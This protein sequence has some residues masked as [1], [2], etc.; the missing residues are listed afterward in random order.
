MFDAGDIRN[1]GL[2]ANGLEALRSA[3]LVGTP[4]SIRI[5]HAHA[6]HFN[7][8]PRI[9]AQS[10]MQDTSIEVAR[11]AFQNAVAQGMWQHA[12]LTVNSGR[13]IVQINVAGNGVDIAQDI[14]GNME[15][16]ELRSV[17]AAQRVAQAQN[18][19]Q[20]RAAQ[21]ASSPVTI[22]RDLRTG[23]TQLYTS[24]NTPKAF[25]EIVDIVGEGAFTSLLGGGRGGS[26]LVR[27]E[28]GHHGGTVSGS[29]AAEGYIRRLRLSMEA[30]GGRAELIT[31]T[32]SGFVD[33]STASVRVLQQIGVNATEVHG[34]TGNESGTPVTERQ[35]N[36]GRTLEI[37]QGQIVQVNQAVQRSQGILREA[38]QARQELISLLN[39]IRP[40]KAAF[41]Q[42]G[43]TELVRSM[44]NIERETESMRGPLSEKIAEF[45]TAFESEARNARGLNANMDLSNTNARLGQMRSLIRPERDVNRIRDSIITH[46][47]MTDHATALTNN[48]FE[49]LAAF[50]QG[51][52][53]RVH[54]LRSAQESLLQRAAAELGAREV[55][56]HV[57]SAWELKRVR[58]S[59]QQ[60]G[61]ILAM[62]RVSERRGIAGISLA[63]Q[64]RLTRLVNR[65]SHGMVPGGGNASRG[66]RIGA[67][68]MAAIEALRLIG[69]ITEN[70]MAGM[71]AEEIRTQNRSIRGHN[72]VAWWLNRG[73]TPQLALLDEDDNHLQVS[74]DVIYGALQGNAS[75]E[76]P[77]NAR[78]VIEDVSREDRLAAVA[79]L[80]ISVH[81]LDDW[82]RTVED[83]RYSRHRHGWQP[84]AQLNDQ[85]VTLRFDMSQGEY[86]GDFDSEVHRRLTTLHERIRAHTSDELGGVRGER[87]TIS[88]SAWV[89]GHDRYAWVYNRAGNLERIDFGSVEP[90]FVRSS[91]Y[92]PLGRIAVRAADLDTYTRLRRYY[93][94]TGR[95]YISEHGGGEFMGPN[96]LGECYVDEDNL[97]RA[98]SRASNTGSS[99]HLD[100]LGDYPLTDIRH[101]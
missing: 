18:I 88:D 44:N 11:Q 99:S 61:R 75:A 39:E 2:A 86:V 22:V 9:L 7:N 27:S 76:I 52:Y 68:F 3:G 45:W 63:R 28:E 55:F 96:H 49:M 66:A 74:Q 65:A 34:P 84:F 78:V 97:E 95:T 77:E 38:Y 42:A 57:R 67:G 5:S 8:L 60:A 89:F 71:E 47:A 59:T 41:S 101:A 87:Q 12:G 58:Q 29:N 54:T 4:E 85:W 36:Q 94:P 21:N 6:D 91:S 16:V 25:N 100:G 46:R 19:N 98:N 35:G 64:M 40:L 82:Y 24:D 73:V 26:Q 10:G 80:D 51:N 31:Q 37:N 33:R 32:D 23:Q 14:I 30:S 43:A 17:S 56:E 79:Q 81:S 62:H 69:E 92:S 15:I 48:A 90:T 53:Q 72:M 70:I 50:R 93:W 83:T 20:Y 1:Q 13:H